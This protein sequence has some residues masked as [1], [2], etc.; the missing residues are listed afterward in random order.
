MFEQKVFEEIYGLWNYEQERC[1]HNKK[2]PPEV[3]NL[4]EVIEIAFL[5]S[6]RREENQP[7]EFSIALIS[8]EEFEEEVKDHPYGN[9][10]IPMLFNQPLTLTVENITKL[11]GAFDKNAT[12]FAVA[13][14]VKNS[15]K[16]FQ[17]WGAL[18]YGTSENMFSDIPFGGPGFTTFKPDNLIITTSSIG[19]LLI[20]R[21][22]H[23][24]GQFDAGVFHRS[25]PTPFATY[26][27][28]NY[29][30][31]SIQYN[32]APSERFD[33]SVYFAALE[34]ILFEAVNRG[35]GGTIIIMPQE[36]VETYSSYFAGNYT[37]SGD[38]GLK[39]LLDE[40]VK[41]RNS[42]L[43]TLEYIKRILAKR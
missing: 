38:L 9:I 22:M 10:Q 13:P 39:F 35:K 24:L 6:L 21:G 5:A 1:N 20:T 42:H 43:S 19:S 4:K 14:V 31:R 40:T 15:K 3:E 25:I 17:I 41:A 12:A 2:D 27:M 28:G 23:I 16:S 7:L 29:L 36:K 37:F 34:H 26:A 11:A 30:I 32:K 33:L 8:R 18:Y